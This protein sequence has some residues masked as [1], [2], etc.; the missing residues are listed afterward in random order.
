MARKSKAKKA[1]TKKSSKASTKKSSKKAGKAKKYAP[2]KGGK[3]RKRGKMTGLPGTLI[4]VVSTIA[5][6]Q[7][8]RDAFSGGFSDSGGSLTVRF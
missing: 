4:V 5:L 1:S 3:R 7:A 8:L 6:P 2:K